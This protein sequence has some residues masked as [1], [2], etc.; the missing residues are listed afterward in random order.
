MA[1][2]YGGCR[3]GSAEMREIRVTRQ[4]VTYQREDPWKNIRLHIDF[5]AGSLVAPGRVA[6]MDQYVGYRG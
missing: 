5:W 4:E 1:A 2:T 3:A 6:L